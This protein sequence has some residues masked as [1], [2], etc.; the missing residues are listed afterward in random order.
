[1]PT[2]APVTISF[3]MTNARARAWAAEHAATLVT[4]IG[5]ETR[6]AIR[7]VIRDAF[8]K[9]L[10]PRQSARLIAPMIGLTSRG[11]GAVLNLAALLAEHPG[12]GV[13]WAGRKRIVVPEDGADDD[14]IDR[15][16]EAYGDRLLS[17]RALSIARTET[18]AA[19]SEGQ[20]LLW[21][22]AVDAGLLVGDESRVWI[23]TPDDRLCPIC[24]E[25]DGQLTGLEDPFEVPGGDLVMGPPAHPQCRCAQGIATEDARNAMEFDLL[26]RAAQLMGV[27]T[28]VAVSSLG[29]P[30]K[31]GTKEYHHAYNK[32]KYQQ[33]KAAKI[34]A[35]EAAKQQAGGGGLSPGVKA[36]PGALSPEEKTKMFGSPQAKP[37]PAPAPPAPPVVKPTPPPAAP[38]PAAPPSGVANPHGPSLQE[39]NIPGLTWDEHSAIRGYQETSDGLNSTLRMSKGQNLTPRIKRID[40]AMQKAPGMT[41]DTEVYRGV[42]SSQAAEAIRAG[43]IGS[44]YVDHAFFSTSF[45]PGRAA[46]FAGFSGN[47]LT[48]KVPK[49]FRAIDMNKA[50][51]AKSVHKH[52]RELLLPRGTKFRVTKI[53]GKNTFMEV[54]P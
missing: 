10:S 26:V 20:R 48:I 41:Y 32:L 42:G 13:V 47:I 1:V 6:A 53:V 52:E 12:G 4:Q 25:M 33:Q 34:A 14:F 29:I 27:E 45:D 30:F 31:G 15:Q 17:D 24:Q 37:A 18:I 40:A 54:I 16:T 7:E 28:R 38:A 36:G 11:A 21:L 22:E 23:T 49:G 51:G 9:G 8:D 5:D 2:K 43:G 44:I 46:G 39:T 19:S 35:K 3:D 50:L